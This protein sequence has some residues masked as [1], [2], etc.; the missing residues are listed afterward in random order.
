MLTTCLYSIL[1]SSKDAIGKLPEYTL[2]I[3]L[4][5]DTLLA[6]YPIQAISQFIQNFCT[7]VFPSFS[8]LIR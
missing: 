8:T 6:W 2:S 1:Y 7:S 3:L 4:A 5:V